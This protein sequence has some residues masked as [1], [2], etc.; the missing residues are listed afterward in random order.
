MSPGA[1]VCPG[2]SAGCQGGGPNDRG[3]P[4]QAAVCVVGIQPFLNLSRSSAKC[5][6]FTVKEEWTDNHEGDHRC[7]H[8]Q[9]STIDHFSPPFWMFIFQGFDSVMFPQGD[10]VLSHFKKKIN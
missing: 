5:L 10:F 6:F 2:L 3:S 1:R 8:H 9:F 4:M 7:R